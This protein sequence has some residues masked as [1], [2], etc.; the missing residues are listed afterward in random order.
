[1]NKGSK[2]FYI[3]P[4]PIEESHEETDEIQIIEKDMQIELIPVK[5]ANNSSKVIFDHF[6]KLDAPID[7]MEIQNN[8]P[9]FIN[10]IYASYYTNMELYEKLSMHYRDGLGGS[11]DAWRDALY[12]TELMLKYE[13]TIA[14]MEHIGDFNTHNLHYCIIKLNSLGEKF[15]L[16]DDTVRYLITRRNKAFEDQPSNKKSEEFDELVELWL[17]RIRKK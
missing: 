6:I 15:L 17:Q 2:H 16:E 3:E 5:P 13:P 1:M 12:L 9:E 11:T 7:L 10:T 8:F 4:I 14:S